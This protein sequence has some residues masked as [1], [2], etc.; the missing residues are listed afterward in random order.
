MGIEGEGVRVRESEEKKE[1]GDRGN[2]E[3]WEGRE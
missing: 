2:E 3:E 1:W